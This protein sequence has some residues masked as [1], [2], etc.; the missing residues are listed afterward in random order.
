MLPLISAVFVASL[1]GSGHCAGMCGAFV[2]FA[3]AGDGAAGGAPATLSVR[4]EPLRQTRTG[5]GGA[6]RLGAAY[7]LGRL[8]TY[9]L[10]GAVAGIVGAALDLGGAALGIQRAAL[11]AA[12]VFMIGFAAVALARS[13][14]VRLPHVPLP[15]A[16]RRAVASGHRAA[17]AMTPIRRAATIGVLT[18]LLPCGWLYAFVV[19]AAGTGSALL[20][21]TTMAVFWLGTVPVLTALGLGVGALGAPLRRRLPAVTAVLLAGVGLW[22]LIGRTHVPALRAS[23]A[24]TAH[25]NGDASAIER[26]RSLNADEMPCCNHGAA[27]VDGG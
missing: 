11:I 18:P 10:L 8:A 5:P 20:G 1:L 12:G 6:L 2:A 9:A 25:A 21:A 3:V 27:A 26:V 24:D 14:G 22:T 16:L 15:H 23:L 17:L 13:I 19:T 4:G 7:N